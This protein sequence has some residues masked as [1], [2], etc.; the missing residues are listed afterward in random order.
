MGSRPVYFTR[1]PVKTDVSAFAMLYG[2]ETKPI[3]QIPSVQ[4]TNACYN[5]NSNS[6]I[7]K[8]SILIFSASLCISAVK[9]CCAKSDNSLFTCHMFSHLSEFMDDGNK[10]IAFHGV[11]H[12]VTSVWLIAYCR[13]LCNKKV[14]VK[15]SEILIVWSASCYNKGGGTR[16][17]KMSGDGVLGTK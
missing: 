11:V 15:T 4:P 17:A 5:S 13:E 2:I 7:S 1:L 10:K 14:I 16:T 6:N 8:R 9:R 12:T 3:F